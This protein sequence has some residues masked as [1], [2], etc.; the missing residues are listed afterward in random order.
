MTSYNLNL[1]NYAICQDFLRGQH[2]RGLP[3]KIEHCGASCLWDISP[4]MLWWLHT[5]PSKVNLGVNVWQVGLLDV[6]LLEYPDK[7]HNLT[8]G[9]FMTPS[10]LNS[11]VVDL[12]AG[13]FFSPLFKMAA[14][15]RCR[16]VTSI[17]T[18]FSTVI[19]QKNLLLLPVKMPL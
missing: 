19:Y 6:V 4:V 12:W 5:N 17:N 7:S 15:Y 9:I 13:N 16:L 2:P 10:L 8:N 1:G 11:I 14:T 18:R 3:A